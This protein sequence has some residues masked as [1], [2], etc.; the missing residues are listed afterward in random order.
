MPREHELTPS[1]AFAP[2]PQALSPRKAR[3]R[4]FADRL[5]PHRESWRRRNAYYHAEELRYLRFLVPEGLSVLA[6]GCGTG[7]TLAALKPSRGVGIDLSPATVDLARSRHPHLDLRIGDVEDDAL[8]ATLDGPFDVILLIDT[9][10]DLEDVEATLSRLHRLCGRDTRIVIAYHSP[11]WEPALRALEQFGLKMPN[12]PQNWL[13]KD[14]VAA[15]MVL[16]EFEIIRHDWRMLLPKHIF[17]LGPLINRYVATLPLVRG[18]C[19]R[20]Y[21]VARSRRQEPPPPLSASVIIP[22]RNERGNIEAAIR[23]IPRFCRD[24]EIIFVEG[25][26]K[27]G[28]LD[29]IERVKAAHP[30]HDIKVFVQP[31]VGKGDAVRKGFAEARG[32]VLMIL[33]ADLTMPPEQLPKFYNQIASGRGE[34]INGSRL[35]Y[36]MENQAMRLLNH[37]ANYVFSK[38][39][40]WLLN[41]RFTDTLCGTKVLMRRHYEKIARNRLYFGEFDPFGDF[42]LIFGAVKLNLK[43]VEIPVR[44]LAREYGET[45]ISRFR[46]GWLLLRMVL[47]AYRKLKAF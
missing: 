34:F 39:F 5:A 33:D 2:V 37:A 20:H 15:L 36:P 35:V 7:D 18:L 19:L 14:D 29:E 16:S 22:A 9:I 42:D 21:L 3:V 13:S 32:D 23:R 46:H 45:Q 6:L 1:G 41:Q 26:S 17:G 44:Y 43:I 8:L 27:D 10:G 11:L 31:G 24:L 12:P 47:F 38:L 4:S 28:T 30:E 40:S 25:H